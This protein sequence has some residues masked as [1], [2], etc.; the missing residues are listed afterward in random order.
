MPNY[1]FECEPCCYHT[2]IF[3]KINEYESVK[4][5]PVCGQE[6]LR[7]VIL[8]AP[9][10]FVRGEPSTIGQLADRNT[11]KMGHYEKQEKE[12]EDRGNT[13]LTPEQK[14]KR[15]QHQKIVSM[16]PEQKIKWIENGD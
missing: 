9:A 1:D 15:E 8:G 16:T 12:N 5:C 2:E 14:A 13:R 10:I 4:T 6:T 3:M 7:R 11:S